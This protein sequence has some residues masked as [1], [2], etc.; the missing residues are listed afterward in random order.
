MELVPSIHYPTALPFLPCYNYMN[1]KHADFP[2]AHEYQDKI[3]SI[4]MFPELKDEEIQK[5]INVLNEFR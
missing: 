1:H 4:P 2:I 3:L 5:V